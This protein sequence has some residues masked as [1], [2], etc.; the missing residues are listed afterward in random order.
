MTVFGAEKN[1]RHHVDSNQARREN[2]PF[3]IMYSKAVAGTESMHIGKR[4]TKPPELLIVSSGEAFRH[5]HDI[6]INSAAVGSV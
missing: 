2:A 1:G 6:I 4:S 5:A 3:A